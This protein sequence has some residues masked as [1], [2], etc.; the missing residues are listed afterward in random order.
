MLKLEPL[1]HN[2]QSLYTAVLTLDKEIYLSI[3]EAHRN[4]PFC[5]RGSTPSPPF[6]SGSEGL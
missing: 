2:S 3:E 4:D 5:Y 1:S 6:Y